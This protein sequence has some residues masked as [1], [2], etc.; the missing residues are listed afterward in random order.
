M[1]PVRVMRAEP[2]RWLTALLASLVAL[3]TLAAA[4]DLPLLTTGP[5]LAWRVETADGEGIIDGFPS[6]ALDSRG[7][8]VIAYD[9]GDFTAVKLA[10]RQG[11]GWT[12]SRLFQAEWGAN[13]SLAIDA[14]DRL[15]L[16]YT[17]AFLSQ[18]KYALRT[19]SGWVT[20]PI[21]GVCGRSNAVIRLDSSG[22][23]HVG[24]AM[25]SQNRVC[26]AV[27]TPSGWAVET[28]DTDANSLWM[29]MDLD[30]QDRPH[31]AYS[32]PGVRLKYATKVGSAWQITVVDTAGGAD[33]SIAMDSQGRPHISYRTLDEHLKYAVL[34]DGVWMKVVVDTDS[35][36]GWFTSID[37]GPD[38]M[39]HIAYFQVINRG[40][41]NDPR[42]G[43]LKYATLLP[44]SM[45]MTE[46]V[47]IEGVT[48][49]DP[50]IVVDTAG[51]PHIAYTFS[52]H[53]VPLPGGS[54]LRYA[55]PVIG[56]PFRLGAP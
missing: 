43:H 54:D 13:P 47:D 19:D 49:F 17:A 11:I 14:N 46:F 15:H 12:I 28:V 45:W 27:K 29:S 33:A 1:R 32:A 42:R 20:E 2:T 50:S 23:P 10:E 31:F 38:D 39:P 44:T 9:D 18:M 53:Q 55:Q 37:I 41:P 52:H 36:T 24:Y 21:D 8:P 22:T 51:R 56:V 34:K 35:P 25:P 3:P 30:S 7:Q 6:I 4:Q 48:G 40:F 26:Y 5:W 16:S